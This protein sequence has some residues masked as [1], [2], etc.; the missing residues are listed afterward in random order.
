MTKRKAIAQFNDYNH[1]DAKVLMEAYGHWIHDH[2]DQGWDAYLFTFEFNQLPG[3][4]PERMRLMKEYLF[5]W[6]GRLATRIVRTPRSP[7]SMPFLP[8][9]ILVPDYPVPKHKKKTLME[10]S[11]NDGLHF[12]G[13]VLATRIGTRLQETLDVHM[14]LRGPTYHTAELHHISVRPITHDPEYVTEYGMKALKRGRF[15]QDD[16]LI[17]PRTVSELPSKGP[18]SSQGPVLAAGERPTYDFQRNS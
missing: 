9:A 5:R 11:V 17:F 4:S 7:K 18:A 8:K 1:H 13:L 16:V 12:H 14:K 10:V 6:Y 3:P 2:M 15:S